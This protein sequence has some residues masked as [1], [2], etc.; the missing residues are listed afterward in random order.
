MLGAFDGRRGWIYHLAVAPGSR[1][2]GTGASLLTELERRLG[3][4]GCL[5][6]NLLIEPENAGVTEFYEHLGYRRDE[7]IFMEKWLDSSDDRT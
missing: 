3:S 4:K 1:R 6:V 5:K 2:A 7:L